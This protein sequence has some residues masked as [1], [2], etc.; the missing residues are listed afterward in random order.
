MCWTQLDAL[1]HAAVQVRSMPAIPAQP[2]AVPASVNR[3]STLP[4][5]LSVAVA[6]PVCAGSL[7]SPHCSCASGG[8]V[9]TGAVVSTKRMCWTQLDTLLHASVAVQVRSMPATP[10][11]PA[12]AA[13]SVCAM[14]GA[15]PQLSVAVAEPVCA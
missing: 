12:A 3:M 11:Q 6:E 15:A 1:P 2:G 8:Q 14:V 7:A 9:T 13:A 10:V 4:P 5:Q